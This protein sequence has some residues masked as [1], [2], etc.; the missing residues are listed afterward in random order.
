MPSSQRVK[1]FEK[2]QKFTGSNQLTY[3]H[4]ELESGKDAFLA[5]DIPLESYY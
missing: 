2:I 5:N 4:I 3:Y 1:D